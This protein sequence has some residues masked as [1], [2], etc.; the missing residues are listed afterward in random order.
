M[1]SRADKTPKNK[2][3]PGASAI[4]KRQATSKSTTKLVD[5][6]P[7]AIVQRN[8]RELANNSSQAELTTQLQIKANNHS[9]VQPQFIQKKENNTGLPDDLKAGIENLSGYSMDDVKVHRN[10]D[11]PAQLQA[12][13]YAQGT[14][15]HLASG[16]EKHLPHEAWHVVQQMQGRVKPTAQ[17]KGKVNVNDDV[18]LEKEA[19]VMGR[20][21]MQMKHVPGVKDTRNT[22]TFEG[23]T[24]GRST[25]QNKLPYQQKKSW[26]ESPIQLLKINEVV[27]AKGDQKEKFIGGYLAFLYDIPVLENTRYEEVLKKVEEKET[28]PKMDTLIEETVFGE[29]SKCKLPDFYIPTNIKVWKEFIQRVCNRDALKIPKRVKDIPQDHDEETEKGRNLSLE[30]VMGKEEDNLEELKYLKGTKVVVQQKLEELVS[31]IDDATLTMN[32]SLDKLFKYTCPQILN[33]MQAMEIFNIKTNNTSDEKLIK[34]RLEQEKELFG[35]AENESKTRIRPLYAALNVTGSKYGA[36]ARNDYGMS[37]FILSKDLEKKCTI[38]LG[39]SFNATMALTY[40]RENIKKLIEIGVSNGDFSLD[41]DPDK[42]IEV[43]IHS[44]IDIRKQVKYI[45]VS[46]LEAK[47]FKIPLNIIKELVENLT[48]NS[49]VYLG[50]M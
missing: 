15:I 38:T 6:R 26:A 4:S 31:K 8:L 21:A 42:Y 50:E 23:I 47:I 40:S 22:Y 37:Y 25:I 32:F 12:H 39:D 2:N 41:Y 36:A 48:D 44:D 11:K 10:S 24:D 35:I 28:N 13:A 30:T 20:K 18:G 45:M 34:Q 9:G 43:Q 49:F 7:Q 14:D 29:D 16:Q 19:D 33:A 3:Q 17:M 1:H 46:K 27:F 5:N